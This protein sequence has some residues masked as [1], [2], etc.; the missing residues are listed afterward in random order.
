MPLA[1]VTGDFAHR[2]AGLEQVPESSPTGE[3]VTALHF[4]DPRGH[5]LFGACAALAISRTVSVTA[6]C[7]RWWLLCS[8]A[9]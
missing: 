7:V 5:A 3:R 4:G 6:T 8:V 9:R 1:L 2:G